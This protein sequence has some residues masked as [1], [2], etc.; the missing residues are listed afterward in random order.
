MTWWGSR[1]CLELVHCEPMCSWSSVYGSSHIQSPVAEYETE[2][3]W[4]V[5][6]SS[7][8]P[9]NRIYWHSGY[10]DCTSTFCPAPRCTLASHSSAEQKDKQSM[11]SVTWGGTSVGVILKVLM[12]FFN[13]EVTFSLQIKI[14]GMIASVFAV[15]Q[16]PKWP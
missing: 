9:I 3:V 12:R 4:R 8:R 5:Q 15:F 16:C 1:V 11:L 2:W 13:R 14:N 10:T 7:A 6:T